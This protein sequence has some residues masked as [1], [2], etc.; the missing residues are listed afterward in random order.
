[1]R[2]IYITAVA[3]TLLAPSFASADPGRAPAGSFELGRVAPR[4]LISPGA[5]AAAAKSK[6]AAATYGGATSSGAP[7]VLKLARG[8]KRFDK[9]GL[10]TRLQCT[11]GQ[12]FAMSLYLTPAKHKVGRTGKFRLA[13]LAT[14]DAGDG[15]STMA[16]SAGV[17]GKVRPG[18]AT[19]TIQL[20]VDFVKTQDGS[21]L[22]SCD[23][24]RERWS[25]KAAPGRIFGG[26]TSAHAPVVVQLS[27]NRRKV[28]DL[29]IAWYAP[30]TND[31]FFAADDLTNFPIDPNGQFGDT[32][33]IEGDMADGT[34]ARLDYEVKGKVGKRK[35]S[36]QL[37]VTVALTAPTGETNNC[38]SGPISWSATS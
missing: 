5:Y 14:A 17:V 8:G 38:D 7:F 19:G 36:G 15:Q 30:C 37:H 11:S 35:A 28:T 13:L 31:L 18:R 1:M 34:H 33:P 4:A 24:V 29:R 3:A 21:K 32:F 9:V 2:S 27:S 23:S 22:D 12:E 20:H 26:V 25:A 16:A 6:P 10:I